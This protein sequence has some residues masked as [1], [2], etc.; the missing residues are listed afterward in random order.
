MSFNPGSGV[1]IDGARAIAVD[2]D[3]G[4]NG[5]DHFVTPDF[6]TTKYAIASATVDSAIATVGSAVV[7]DVPVI[8]L[9]LKGTPPQTKP[10]LLAFRKGVLD[11]LLSKLSSNAAPIDRSKVI[12]GLACALTQLEFPG[13]KHYAEQHPRTQIHV[14]AAQCHGEQFADALTLCIQKG[15]V[16]NVTP[17]GL[18]ASIAFRIAEIPHR[19][20]KRLRS[21]VTISQCGSH[22]LL[23]RWVTNQYVSPPNH[24]MGQLGLND[25]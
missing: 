17:H 5:T 19:Q 12:V 6:G 18:T 16:T 1:D 20:T 2:I 3:A 22:E 23:E 24:D 8:V 15:D 13:L 11:K 4:S 14:V 10:G 7:G 21:S 9:V 25:N